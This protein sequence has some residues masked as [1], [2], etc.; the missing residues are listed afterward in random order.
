VER[1]A[2]LDPRVGLEWPEV[3]ET[4]ER[5]NRGEATFAGP[6][7][8]DREPETEVLLPRLDR[9]FGESSYFERRYRRILDEHVLPARGPRP[10]FLFLNLHMATIAEPDPALFSRWL[11]RTVLVNLRAKGGVVYPGKAP[12]D[13]RG[14][15]FDLAD[16]L[17][18]PTGPFPSAALR[19]KH[20]FDN[21]FYD[22]TFRAVMGHLEARG[23]TRN[24]LTVVTSDHGMSL[25]EHG[26]ALLQH[27]GA[28]PY[29]YITNV[30]LVIR[31]PPGSPFARLHRVRTEK[32]SLLDLFP[33]LLHVGLGPGVFE[34]NLPVR[35]RSLIERVEQDDFE[36]VVVSECS[37][38]PS[39]SD[40]LPNTAAYAKA[41]HGRGLKLIHAPRLF[42]QPPEGPGWPVRHRLDAPWTGAGP[43]PPLEAL[44]TPLDRLFDLARDPQE[45]HDLASAR[46]EEAERLRRIP[47]TWACEPLVAGGR[48]PDFDP[49]ARETLKAL[50]YLQ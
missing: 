38:G 29:E 30:P 42:R 11:L 46:P 16:R 13:V 47:S 18:L 20:I 27:G 3:R 1:R 15:L 40:V 10:F 7:E 4:I 6:D 41:V 22:A 9:L 23:L 19:L 17:G 21:R 5:F 12:E 36:E 44:S 50:G 24:L 34:R 43:R 2:L 28:R 32:V 33:T 37:L 39:T 25:R 49:A 45:R 35:G 8:L 31:F 26:E 48:S 14:W